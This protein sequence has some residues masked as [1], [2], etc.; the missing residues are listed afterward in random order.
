[1]MVMIFLTYLDAEDIPSDEDGDLLD[2][3]DLSQEDIEQML[4]DMD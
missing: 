2:Y 3:D 4:E 1:M